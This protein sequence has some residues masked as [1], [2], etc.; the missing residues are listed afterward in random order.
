MAM[1]L[2]WKYEGN[3]YM[4]NGKVVLA[5]DAYNK[6]LEKCK[7]TKQE[8]LVLF[9]RATAYWKQAQAQKETLQNEVEEWE[10][11]QAQDIQYLLSEGL[12]GGE[13]GTERAGLAAS[14]LE[15]LNNDGRR[16][17]TELRKIQYRHG[18]YQYALLHA[19]QDSL[20]ATEILPSYSAAWLQAGELLGQL[21][22][23]KESRQYC[24]MAQTL[25]ESR[26]ESSSSSSLNRK[27]KT[28]LGDLGRRQE[29]LEQARSQSDW[30]EDALR[31]ALDVAG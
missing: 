21:W 15:K 9:S 17:Q 23:L 24:E 20:R 18:L 30:P 6:A 12:L 3:S 2:K 1:A 22:K 29:L 11:P 10:L 14:I 27:L 31:L 26:D 5:I 28:L 25:G 16:Q 19:T 7:G 4:E 13:A 8:G